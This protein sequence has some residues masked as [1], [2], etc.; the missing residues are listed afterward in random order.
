MASL[1]SSVGRR[2]LAGFLGVPALILA[3]SRILPGDPQAPQIP[4]AKYDPAIFQKPMPSDQVAFLTR[5]AGA[6]AGDEVRDKQ[7]RKL[8]RSVVP[9][10][11]FHY[12]RD[13]PLAD[14]VEMVLKNSPTPIQIRDGRYVTVSGQSGPYLTGRGFL[15]IDMQEG[16]GLGG[17]YFH[18]TNGEPTPTVAIF[19]RHV[20]EE[21][22]QMTELP[23]PFIE[24]LNLWTRR[25]GIPPI[26]TRY[27]ITGSNKRILLEHDEDYCASGNAPV[28]PVGWDCQQMNANAA[29]IDET[30]AYY[31]DQ[32]HYATNATAWMIGPDQVAWLQVRENTCRG[33]P[34]ALGCR[35]RVTREHTLVIIH[36]HPVPHPPHR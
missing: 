8:M 32:V 34:D 16:I 21:T 11:M 27:F 7:F 30:A 23:P 31:L 25:S 15:W 3:A 1:L 19:S 6:A 5:L 24:D 13:M 36:K 2:K 18:P 28:A 17:F 4:Q 22:L 26:T 29:D 9:D 10:C 35:I 20:K 12:G 33:V 14:A